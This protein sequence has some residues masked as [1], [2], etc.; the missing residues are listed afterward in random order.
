MRPGGVGRHDHAPPM[1]ESGREAGMISIETSAAARNELQAESSSMP[2]SPLDASPYEVLGVASTVTTQ[3]LRRAYRHRMRETHPDHGGASSEFHAVQLAWEQ[4]GTVEARTAYDRAA[5]RGSGWSRRPRRCG[6]AAPPI[7]KTSRPQAR[8]NGHPGGYNRER[9]LAEIR[10]GWVASNRS[11]TRTTPSWCA[12]RHARSG[13][14]SPMP[15]P[16]R[17]P[18]ANSSR[19]A[20]ASPSGTTSWPHRRPAAAGSASSITSRS[21]RPGCGRSRARTGRAGGTQT[22]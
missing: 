12:T 7:P 21:G 14:C 8:A 19:S 5:S 18:R 3:E 11:R 2:D 1:R 13:T 15:S 6:R 20:W 17:G 4:V 16:R 9:Y 22:R 10:H